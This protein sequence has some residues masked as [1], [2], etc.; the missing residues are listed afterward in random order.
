MVGVPRHFLKFLHETECSTWNTVR[1]LLCVICEQPALYTCVG[2][3]CRVARIAPHGRRRLARLTLIAKGSHAP[4]AAGYPQGA[5]GVI[6]ISTATRHATRAAGLGMYLVQLQL[7]SLSTGHG[8]RPAGLVWMSTA[9]HRRHQTTASGQRTT[10]H[11]QT[12]TAG[13]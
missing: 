8:T 9:K 1:F 11:G 7:R 2:E 12:T 3:R 4:R 13:E 6:H 5:A 10:G